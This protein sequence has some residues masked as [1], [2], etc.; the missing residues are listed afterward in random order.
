MKFE[1]PQEPQKRLL[2][3][4]RLLW[5][6]TFYRHIRGDTEWQDV[7]FQNSW[8]NAGGSLATAQYRL[9]SGIVFIK[10]T[11]DTGTATAGT[12]IFALPEGYRPAE[13][14]E[15]VNISNGAVGQFD[16]QS[17]GD[18]V[19]QVGSNTSFALTCSFYAE[20]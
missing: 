4:P 18:V 19:I 20:Q 17:D 8:A 5:V 14:L 10:G 12:V 15:F 13:D 6:A 16:V 2:E 7:S 9:K 1:I 11:V 3:D